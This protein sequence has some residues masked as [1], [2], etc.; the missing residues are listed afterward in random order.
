MRHLAESW[1]SWDSFEIQSFLPFKSCKEVLL[2]RL[3]TITLKV[4]SYSAC[5]CFIT[6]SWWAKTTL[7]PTDIP[8]NTPWRRS[9]LAVLQLFGSLLSW[10]ETQRLSW[11]LVR[12]GNLVDFM[13][14]DHRKINTPAQIGWTINNC[15][16]R[17]WRGEQMLRGF[18]FKLVHNKT[19]II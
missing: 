17:N 13:Q 7:P 4:P 12:C 18:E 2:F 8:T 3:I 19:V 6:A 5:R 15:F 16:S 14:T 10:V 9:V 1:K 11:V